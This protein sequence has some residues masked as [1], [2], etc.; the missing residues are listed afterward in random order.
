MH[1]RTRNT[2]LG[3]GFDTTLIEK[4]DQN[5]HTVGKFSTLS[6]AALLDLKKA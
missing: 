1:G 6:K 3:Y 2:L 4:I 5:G